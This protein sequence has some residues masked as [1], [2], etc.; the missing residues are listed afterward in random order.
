MLFLYVSLSNTTQ[1]IAPSSY[2]LASYLEYFRSTFYLN[3]SFS[4]EISLTS[5]S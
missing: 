1:H 5:E 4:Y 3:L 2:N